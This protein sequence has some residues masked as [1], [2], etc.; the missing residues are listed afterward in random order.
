M[1]SETIHETATEYGV[2]TAS[3]YDAF[4]GVDHDEDPRAKGYI[5]S[6]GQHTLPAGQVAQVETLDALGYEPIVP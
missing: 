5:G 3:M 2:L 1:W 4:N 6:D